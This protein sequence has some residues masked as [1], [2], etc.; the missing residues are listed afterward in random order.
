MAS[1]K[2]FNTRLKLK[3]DTFDNWQSSTFIPLA[4]E[5][6]ICTSGELTPD[7]DDVLLKV[8]NGKDRFSALPWVSAMAGDVHSWAKQSVDEF[9]GW[10]AKTPKT[11]TLSVNDE[12]K[13]YTIEEAIKLIRNEIVAGGE[14]SAIT[15]SDDSVNGKIKYTA[16]Q[17][18]TD[19][20]ES[21]EINSGDGLEITIDN[22]VPKI[23]HKDAPESG[24]AAT[25]KNTG[26]GRTYV[27]DVIVDAMGHVSG[28]ETHTEEVVNTNTAHTHST[29]EKSG[30]KANGSGGLEGDTSFEL[31]VA[32]EL[33]DRNIV[34]YD[35]TDSSKTAL[36]TLDA[37]SFIKD[38]MIKSVELVQENETGAKG[39]FLKIVWNIDDANGTDDDDELDVVYVDVNDL[40]DP[41]EA[42][43]TSL[44]I[45]DSE[46]KNTN[47]FKIKDSGVSTV[48]IAD[49][50]VTT[51]KLADYS[52]GATQIKASADYTGDD[53]EV[54]VFDC[55]S[56]SKLIDNTNLQ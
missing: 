37:T 18:G 47:V 20:V 26:S 46:G 49:K 38:G 34:L 50:A 7:T 9:A 27:T 51:G 52:V 55:G 8:G 54:W 41:Y 29:K 2:I 23:S 30:I 5:V 39:Q 36:A 40:V 43:E 4:G 13:T 19:I 53:A 14:T 10:V 31:N 16:K 42:D 17:G 35:K 48:K 28:V 33:I 3:Y 44:T 6:C 21:I 1:N 22:N 12:E 25:K 32:L 45:K 24:S 15:I 56:S 11:V